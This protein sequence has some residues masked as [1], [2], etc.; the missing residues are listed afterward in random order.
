M[1]LMKTY[2]PVLSSV[3]LV[4]TAISLPCQAELKAPL[5]PEETT[6]G[7]STLA[8][9]DPLQDQL[10]QNTAVLFNKK[11]LPAATLTWVGADGY[12]ITKASEVP[13]ME[14]C[15]VHYAAR[16]HSAVREIRRDVKS[17]LVLGQAVTMRDVPAIQFQ[18]SNG[19]TFGQWIAS[20]AGGKHVKL[21]VV[22]ANRRAIKG[23]G[24]AIGVRM[25]DQMKGKAKG[26]RII[27]VAEDSPAAAAGLR[28]NDI[29]LELA[30][31]SVQEY[32][33]VNEIISQRQPGEEIE[34]K[35]KRNDTEKSLYVRLASRTKVLSNWEGEDFANGGISIRTDNFSEVIQHDMPLHPTDMGGVVTDLL[36]HAIGI[37]I[38]RVDRV[39]TFALP[40]E[41]FWPLIQE[42]MQKDRHPPK[43]LPA[44]TASA[45]AP[46]APT[47]NP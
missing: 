45:A 33:R 20:P 18:P 44:T 5:L 23:F 11:G 31:E 30:G 35:F 22:S 8:P 39:T 1:T 37:N 9:L 7:K 13:R 42:W 40:T 6:N 36:G 46:A 26:V 34:V 4:A 21:G 19:L 3:L 32:R 12:F 41:R 17:D 16:P 47:S 29:M 14:E 25:D 10:A 43:A 2:L 28:A 38:A 27:G 15:Q 24:A